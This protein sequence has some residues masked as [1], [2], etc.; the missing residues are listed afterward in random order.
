MVLNKLCSP[1]DQLIDTFYTHSPK[2]DSIYT[3]AAKRGPDTSY[4]R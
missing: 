3:P 2:P 1:P 4:N